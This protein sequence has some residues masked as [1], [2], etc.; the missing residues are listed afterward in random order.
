MENH[1]NVS[2]AVFFGSI[3]TFLH[4]TYKASLPAN[5]ITYIIILSS[6]YR[7]KS[8][9]R[10]CLCLGFQAEIVRNGSA[11]DPI[12]KPMGMMTYLAFCAHLLL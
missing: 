4:L 2:L 1:D 7:I 5:T 6:P 8:R 11:K 3:N 12:P 10:T 9:L